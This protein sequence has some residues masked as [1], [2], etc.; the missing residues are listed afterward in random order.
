M[1]P[2][3]IIRMLAG[4]IVAILFIWIIFRQL[5]LM[6]FKQAFKGA[7]PSWIIVAFLAFLGGYACRIERWRLMLEEENPTLTWNK[8]AGPLLASFAANNVLPFRAGDIL[9]AF[10]FCG[11]LGVGSAAVIATLLAERLLDLLIVLIIFGVMLTILSIDGSLFLGVGSTVLIGIAIPIIFLLFFPSLFAPIALIPGR[12]IS[13]ITPISGRRILDWTNKILT[14]LI[15]LSQRKNMLN[16]FWWSALA[17]LAEGCVFW[18]AALALP[19]I[20][21]PTAGWLGMP[22]ATLSTLIPSTPGYIGTFDYFTMYAMS[23]LGN[24]ATA[25]TGYAFLVHALIWVPP[26]LIGGVYLLMHS[27]IKERHA[28]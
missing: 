9:R 11:P 25:S 18:A 5:N 26:T 4:L 27:I 24:N 20:S 28:G 13:R 6:E 10:S 8:C 23:I 22:V 14:T 17:W 19:S 3:R 16:L 2:R 21:N 12:L 15:H 1:T 7:R